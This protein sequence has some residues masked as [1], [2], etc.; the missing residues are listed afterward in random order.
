MIDDLYFI[1]YENLEHIKSLLGNGDRDKGDLIV[2]NNELY[3]C[4]FDIKTIRSDYRHDLDHGDNKKKKLFNVGECYKQ[5]CGYRPCHAK[6][7][8]KVQD[9][10][11]N[12]I[13]EL[14]LLLISIICPEL[15]RDD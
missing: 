2:R 13:L 4:I 7:Y 6:D 11:Y 9:G 12:K 1:F 5:Y 8:R 14:Q 10:L 3:K 15:A